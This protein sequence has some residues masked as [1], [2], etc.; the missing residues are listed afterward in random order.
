[1]TVPSLQWFAAGQSESPRKDNAIEG[2]E[3]SPEVAALGEMFL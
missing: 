1:M 3:R 2:I